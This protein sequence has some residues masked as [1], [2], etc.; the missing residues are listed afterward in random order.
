[1]S[2]SCERRI[3]PRPCPPARVPLLLA[4]LL[5]SPG[6]ALSARA[7]QSPL[8]R[9]TTGYVAD[10]WMPQLTDFARIQLD[11]RRTV[12]I[13][14]TFEVV[15]LRSQAARREAVLR[16]AARAPI[17]GRTD[18]LAALS[19]ESWSIERGDQL[20]IDRAPLATAA[21]GVDHTIAPY[22]LGPIHFEGYVGWGEAPG[23]AGRVS[24]TTDDREIAIGG[25]RAET[26]DPVVHLPD[27]SLRT[28]GS[29]HRTTGGDL[30]V[31]F[32]IGM[33]VVVVRPWIEARRE[34]FGRAEA[35]GD[36]FLD[37]FPVGDQSIW[38]T[39]LS[40]VAGAWATALAY[41]RRD[42]D[43]ESAVERSGASA[44]GIPI[45]DAEY[46]SWTAS[47]G[48]Q[49]GEGSWNV[50][51][52]SERLEGRISARVETWPF[53]T[54]WESVSAQAYRMNGGLYGRSTR[55]AFEVRAPSEGGWGWDAEFGRYS[56]RVDRVSWYVT[57]LG[58][59]RSNRT[60]SVA[61]IESANLVAVGIGHRGS[62]AGGSLALR[63]EGGV[64]V[65]VRPIDL[66][67]PGSD[68]GGAAGY[69]RALL[70]W[71]R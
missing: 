40:V 58:F 57:S 47:V 11:G 1:M 18:V 56:L 62:A 21:L 34:V 38:A 39:G 54:L 12:A 60:R 33:D 71:S 7:Q 45:A 30:R 44:G 65:S 51:A 50:R 9:W 17:T 15:S 35:A 36:E 16:T 59:G 13:T 37:A 41:R 29:R 8:E 43:L 46:W 69:L 48:R 14:S 52:A 42:L 25:W 53:L 20:L 49:L 2:P 31:R 64:P 23:V 67:R 10:A 26:R 70:G 66:D 63:L 19:W 28:M 55:L 27:D 6:T 5:T 22:D 24:Q 4:V 32:D 61:G 68:G 3:E